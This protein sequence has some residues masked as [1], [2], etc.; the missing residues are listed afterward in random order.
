M[1]NETKGASI[2]DLKDKAK[3]YHLEITDAS[4]SQILSLKK[5]IKQF[6]ALERA[7]QWLEDQYRDASKAGHFCVDL[8]RKYSLLSDKKSK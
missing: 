6:E 2:S 8:L 1:N 3:R 7:N 5:R 4:R